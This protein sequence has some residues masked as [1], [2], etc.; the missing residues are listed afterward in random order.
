MLRGVFLFLTRKQLEL[1]KRQTFSPTLFHI[2]VTQFREI[3]F[4]I[5][6]HIFLS[7]NTIKTTE[8]FALLFSN[9]TAH[10]LKQN[11]THVCSSSRGTHMS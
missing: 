8:M 7:E 6:S 9:Y 4:I 5:I 10:S 3:K 11:K 1:K 2:F